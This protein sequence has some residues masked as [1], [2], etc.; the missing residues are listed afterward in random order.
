MRIL[1]SA[2]ACAPNQGSEE[3]VG[4]S[5]TFHLAQA[6]HEVHVLTRE[7][8]RPAIEAQLRETA[9]PNVRFSYIDVRNLPFWMPALGVYPY[10]MCWQA[11][12]YFVARRLHGSG[13]FD[14]VHHLTYGVFRHPSYLFLLKVPFV[15]G[16]VGGGERSPR[17]LRAS[18]TPRG[19]LFEALRRVANW[20]PNLDPAW[21]L[22]LRNSDR[23]AVKTEETL[24]CLPAYC[25]ERAVVE[26]ENMLPISP[27]IA[28]SVRRGAPLKL[29]YAGRLLPWKG[30]HLAIRALQHLG[31]RVDVRMTVVGRGP[32]EEKLKAEIRSLGLEGVVELKAWLPRA[33]VLGLYA[34]HDALIFPSL[35]DSSGTVVMEAIAHGRP[36]ICL[37]LGGPK[38]TVDPTCARIVATAGK[39]EAQVVESLAD[40][41]ANLAGLSDEDWAEIRRAAIRRAEYFAPQQVIA[42]IYGPLAGPLLVQPESGG[43]CGGES[44]AEEPA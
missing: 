8:Y 19:K 1:L 30:V 17:R 11:K 44:F 33:E 28:G 29:L 22:M 34:T 27:A 16:P 9:I 4:W 15:F 25:A 20:L 24:A 5:W 18:M 3:G 32:E 41:I 43:A 36:V 7:F 38:I 23:I 2:F 35:H 42:R 6:G 13:P 21:R 26:M 12:A 31:G 37:D 39:S 14:L 10:Y 40:A